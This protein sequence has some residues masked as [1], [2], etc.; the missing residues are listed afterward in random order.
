MRIR[1]RATARSRGVSSSARSAPQRARSASPSR[2]WSASVLGFC[3]MAAR[4]N[5]SR[6]PESPLSRNRSKPWCVFK[7]AKRISNASAGL[8]K[9]TLLQQRRT[10]RR[11]MGQAPNMLSA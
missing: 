5:P 10:N 4:W 2:V 8:V 11:K 7:Y 3:A 1:E 6:A 9:R